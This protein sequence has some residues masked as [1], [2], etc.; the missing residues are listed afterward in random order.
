[1]DKALFAGGC[2]WCLE[3]LFNQL[4][5]VKSVQ[6]GYSG[7]TSLAPS[8]RE[9]C[10]GTTGHAECIEV[11]F[12]PQTISYNTLLQVFFAIHDPT[13]PNRQ[14]HDIGSQ[15]RSAIFTYNPE[16]QRQAQEYVQQLEAQQAFAT[17]I[18]TE[19][20]P[21]GIFYP[22]ETEH[23][24]YYAENRQAPYCQAVIAPKDIH[25]QQRFKTLL[26]H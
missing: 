20:I 15:Y 10:S 3:A 6:S 16:Q 22:A 14:G 7:G 18:V 12:D 11:E 13:T 17:P 8:Y 9:V 24:Q 21:A 2:F 25:F 23:H 26:T 5:G 19:I 1:M 4:R